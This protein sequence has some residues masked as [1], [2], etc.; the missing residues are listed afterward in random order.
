MET[1]RKKKSW[2]FRRI[3]K[4]FFLSIFV[5]IVL[6]IAYFIYAIQI[7]PP[8]VKEQSI[9][10][11]KRELLDTNFYAIKNNRFRKSESG[12][13]ELYVEGK[14]FERGVYIGKL[15]KELIQKQEDAFVEQLKI[16][17]PSETFLK[18]LKYLTAWFNR[19]MDDYI[20]NEYLLEIY[21]V[22]FSASSK[23]S[24]IGTNYQR[25]LNYHGAHDIGHALADVSKV[26]CTSFSINNDHSE[27]G[28]LLIGRNFD[29]Y[30]GDKFAEDKIVAFYNPDKGHKF[31]IITWG[32]FTGVVSGMN[33]QGLTVTLN[34]AKS[35]IPFSAKTPI[36]I[37]ARE[38]LQYAKNID[39]AFV[40]AKKRQS[41]VAEAIMI[42]SKND[43]KTVIIE[44][45][46]QKIAIFDSKKDIIIG[47]NHY[48]SKVFEND[49][50]NIENI[51]ESSSMYRFKRMTQLINNYDKV[52][53]KNAAEILR[54]KLGLN[55]KNIGLTNEK[56]ICQ[57]IS[58]HA[59][60]FK[61]EEL[62]MWVSTNPF[63]LGKFV[64]YDLDS[65][66]KNYPGMTVN[67]EIYEK[68]LTISPDSFLLSEGYKNF[69]TF[70]KIKAQ[71][72][73]NIKNANNPNVDFLLIRNFIDSNPE[74]FY[75]YSLSG[76]YCFEKKK[77]E[78]ALEYYSK[79]L[80][81]EITTVPE[82]KHILE[83]IQLIKDKYL[84]E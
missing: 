71:I 6:F 3:L 69:K 60:I 53:Y 5:L 37:I 15:T 64:C 4:Y 80:E 29:F 38:I 13:Y 30:V 67:K 65:V 61:P 73:A 75:T 41:F 27:D 7:T 16:M 70:K 66:F 36:S 62:K 79:A 82:K 81:K 83:Q 21:G 28:N 48:Q 12:L 20:P 77:F 52:N 84:N 74:Y 55:D 34:A 42:G 47:P 54:N 58:H 33:D 72:K 1:Y 25:I 26:G 49:P 35:E 18:Y 50:L 59:V 19:N 8:K 31:A 46:P 24:D 57:L 14:P 56:N 17:I 22:S 40:I 9:L 63:Q 23:H 76:D 2:T 51:K 10:K 45:S 43:K 32:G 44:K 78:K 11:E 68:E 39:E